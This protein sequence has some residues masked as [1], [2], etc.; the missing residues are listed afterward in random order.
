MKNS[1]LIILLEVGLK[2]YQK[3]IKIFN[4]KPLEIGQLNKQLMNLGPK[5]NSLTEDTEIFDIAKNGHIYN[6]KRPNKLSKDTT[7]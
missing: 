4:K 3:N 5:C 2:V 7:Y 6:Y 1:V